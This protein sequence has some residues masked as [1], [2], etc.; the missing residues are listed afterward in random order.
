MMRWLALPPPIGS[1]QTM[2]DAG[3]LTEDRGF[4][5]LFSAYPRETVAVFAPE[6]LTSAVRPRRW[7]YWPKS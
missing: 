6:L 1:V 5:A 7:R 4:K 3:D 2:T